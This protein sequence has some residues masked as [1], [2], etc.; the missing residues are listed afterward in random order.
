MKF[1]DL[2]F[3]PRKDFNGI[4]AKVFFANKYGASIIQGEGTHGNENGLYELAVLTGSAD[5]WHRCN[6]TPLTDGVVGRLSESEVTNW[7]QNIEAL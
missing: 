3:S 1:K 5:D 7:L 2:E 4:Q 6:S